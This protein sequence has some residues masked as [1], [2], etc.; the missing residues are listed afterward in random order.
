MVNDD[1][2]GKAAQDIR[3]KKRVMRIIVN[4]REYKVPGP[5]ISYAQVVALAFTPVPTGPD[6]LFTVTYRKGPTQNPKGTLPEGE[7]VTIK[8]GMIFNVTQT[9]RS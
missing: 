2:D 7:S 3:T 5:K 4:A 9:N 8:N 6:V 1:K